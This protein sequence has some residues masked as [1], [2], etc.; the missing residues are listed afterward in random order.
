[1][2]DFVGRVAEMAMLARCLTGVRAGTARTVLVGGDA[3]IGKSRL[4]S[5]F[6]ATAR[7]S[8]VRVLAAACEEHF[9]DPTPYGPLLEILEDFG[10][11]F[12]AENEAYHRLNDFFDGRG[13]HISGPQQ[14]F[15]NVRRMLQD[16]EAPLVLVI[17]D[18][19]WADP[20]TLD[21]VRHL[22]QARAE[23]RRLLIL[24][25]YRSNGLSRTDPL[26][27]LLAS[28]D[29]V[30][31]VERI[32]LDPFTLE[33]LAELLS[34]G[35]G[36]PGP[37]LV[38]RCLA[39]SEGNPFYAEQLMA[40]GALDN[41]ENLRLPADLESV[42]LARLSGLSDDALRVLRVAAVAGR[43]ISRRL[44]RLV[45]GFE[46][47]DLGWIVQ[48]CFDRQ[49][50]VTGRNEDDYQFRHALLRE[51]V[52]HTT[53]R[54]IRVDLHSAM[55]R[56]LSADAS[57]SLSEGSAAAELAGHWYQA[58]A[59]P[60][61]LASA[62]QAG[63]QAMRTFAFKSAE[64]QF[65][66][67]LKLWPRVSRSSEVAG[68]SH[69][70]LLV[71]M[72]EAARWSGSTDRALTEIENAIAEAGTDRPDLRERH[73]SYLWEAGRRQEAGRVFREAADMLDGQ[74]PS[75]VKARVL[76]AIALARLHAGRYADGKDLADAAL[77]VAI[78][79]GARAEEG[80]ALNVSG[81]ARGMLGEFGDGV[82]RLR[83]AITVAQ[84][85][86]HI[87]DLLRAYANLGLTL[88]N[89]G[90]LREAAEAS[91]TGLAE[92]RR[93]DLGATTQAMI[94]AN[95]ASVALLM[96]GEWRAAEQII[97]EVLLDRPVAE[98]I[99]PRL[100]LAEIKTARGA[101]GQARALLDAIAG[102]ELNGDP[103][104]LGPLHTIRALIALGDNDLP[105][106]VREVAR[107]VVALGD[108][109]NSLER[110]RLCAVGLRCAADQ[111][112]TDPRGAMAVGDQLAREGFEARP[113]G[114]TPETEQLVRL[115]QA[116]RQRL[117]GVESA[118]LWSR[119]ADGWIRLDRP[120]EAAYARWRQAA[121]AG[122]R[123]GREPLLEAHRE[124]GRLGA[125][126]LLAGL[127]RLA[128]R[129]GLDL[130]DRPYGLT[131]AELETLQLLC[132]GLDALRIARARGVTRRTAETQ[133][134]RV[135]RKMDVGGQV[136]A[137]AKARRDNVCR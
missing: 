137:T 37:A 14:V 11:E 116:E 63:Q 128:R 35:S 100:T 39:W 98:S 25:S 96:L 83:R 60:E 56:A 87:E 26:R 12:G 42:L 123:T 27:Q 131:E 16:V 122:P 54:D 104:F 58:G 74:P 86:N 19:H 20:S 44:L 6:A 40:A 88:E 129:F 115:C 127:V 133:L 71:E 120:Y 134:H 97:T 132:R 18:L 107:G 65:D 49:M 130:A 46:P 48:E 76:A 90:R 23:E 22:A 135:Y 113:P 8:H 69:V 55:A 32:E 72:A 117:Q 29:F 95:N 121:A 126:P 114:S 52:H 93:L 61:A 13:E 92:G 105:E 10:R 89:A 59:W 108:G 21:L 75:A 109:E 5:N 66:R 81:L 82:E 24:C 73:G 34:T 31:R 94:L 106:A 1:V 136:E 33:D 78:D 80:R 91:M 45:S 125:E 36:G 41:P 50:L 28:A 119:V 62:V 43:T 38:E 67:A 101:F 79:A 102:V 77:R 68:L 30:R 17:E 15:V 112:A 2:A 118:Q 9:G 84:A 124:A 103:R 99:Y 57:L 51:A 7:E 70:H 85:E 53:V 3:G 4:L 111:A 110:L 64:V 47:D